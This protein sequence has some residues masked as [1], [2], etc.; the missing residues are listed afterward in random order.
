MEK[1]FCKRFIYYGSSFS[2]EGW[3]RR[4]FT[5]NLFH[6]RRSCLRKTFFI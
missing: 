1:D 3:W 2:K 6:R 5:K 4:V